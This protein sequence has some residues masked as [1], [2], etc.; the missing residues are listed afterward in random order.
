MNVIFILFVNVPTPRRG[1]S[2]RD[3]QDGAAGKCP[4]LFSARLQ[5]PRFRAHGRCTWLIG[6]RGSCHLSGSSR[7][8]LALLSLGTPVALLSEGRSSPPCLILAMPQAA[9][10]RPFLAK[11]VPPSLKRSFEKLDAALWIAVSSWMQ[12]HGKVR[13]PHIFFYQSLLNESF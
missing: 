11:P 5:T 4:I 9:M 1:R 13:S 7:S 6:M 3:C 10:D 8:L 2:L 12:R